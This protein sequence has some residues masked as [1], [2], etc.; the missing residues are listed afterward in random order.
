[1]LR[2]LGLLLLVVLV[3]GA[4]G[5]WWMRGRVAA[6]YRG[7]TEPEVFVELPAGSGVGGIARRLADAGVVPDSITFRLAVR[8]QHLD[9]R[10]EAGEYR[11]AD[12]A[13]PVEVAERMA[14]GDVYTRSVTFPEGLTITEMAAIFAKSGIGTAEEFEGAALNPAAAAELAPE[15]ENLEGLLF[16]STYSLPRSAGAEGTVSAMVAQFS[17][18]FDAEL[19]AAAAQQHMSL[20]E[21]VTLASIIEK[22]SAR[23]D[24]RPIISAV[25]RNR[26]KI[27]MPLQCDPTVIYALMQAGR[28]N[29]NLRK[30]D[31]RMDSR[32]NTYRYPGLPPGPIASPGRGALEAAVR[33][34]DVKYLY[35]VSRND[36]THVFAS[37]LAEHSK[38][39]QRWQVRYFRTKPAAGAMKIAR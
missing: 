4:A 13:S 1:M 32:Y 2:R 17:R 16:P 14:R 23:E 26:L 39:V 12:A 7:F 20:R 5:A 29:G 21:V 10:L 6:Q 35:F 34:A 24:E 15:V 36:G 33:P 22:E 8:L 30:Q 37:T 19:R 9:R 3:A 28:W 25:Y 11:F 38:N 31:L 18:N 27:G